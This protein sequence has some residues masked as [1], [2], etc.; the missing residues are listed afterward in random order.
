MI[1][2][3]AGTKVTELVGYP[4]D[5]QGDSFELESWS[6]SSVNGTQWVYFDLQGS[7]ENGLF[8]NLCPLLD[9]E[10][11]I[12]DVELTLKEVDVEEPL[13]ATFTFSIKVIPFE[14][15][16]DT[17]ESGE[18]ATTESS[19]SSQ[20]STGITVT[21]VMQINSDR[22]GTVD[23]TEENTS[24]I[25]VAVSQSNILGQFEMEFNK[26][27]AAPGGLLKWSNLNEGAQRINIG[28]ELSNETQ[29]ILEE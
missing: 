2:V 1:E 15:K 18:A 13:S 29:S 11:Q 7:I 6:T 23:K 26:Y 17:T 24:E 9:A 20:A 22:S 12:I 16:T 4:I 21:E 3:L 14:E 28:L 25:R 5:F 8:V 10:E 19:T 27:I